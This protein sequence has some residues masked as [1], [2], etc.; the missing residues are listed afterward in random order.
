M[1]GKEKKKVKGDGTKEGSFISSFLGPKP[2][3]ILPRAS[4]T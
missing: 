3:A 4:S 1:E 2:T